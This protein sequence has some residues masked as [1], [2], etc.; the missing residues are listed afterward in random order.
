MK[1]HHSDR[2]SQYTGAQFQ[3]LMADHGIACSLSR[4]G[5]VWHNAEMETVRGGG[6]GFGREALIAWCED[7]DVDCLFSRAGNRR[8][9]DQIQAELAEAANERALNDA[10]QLE[11]SP[12]GLRQ[13]RPYQGRGQPLMSGRCIP[14]PALTLRPRR[15]SERSRQGATALQRHPS[16]GSVTT[17]DFGELDAFA[18]TRSV[19]PPRLKSVV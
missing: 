6:L 17:S 7:N 1:L 9:L 12:A 19:V 13:G 11:T 18:T 8:L 16:R 4:S 14:T 2:G 3:R 5:N 15:G 10:L